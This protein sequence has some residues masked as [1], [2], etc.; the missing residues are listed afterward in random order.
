MHN[1][2]TPS[3]QQSGLKLNIDANLTGGVVYKL[4]IDFDAARSIV[5]KGNG[6]YLLK[7]VIRTYTEAVSGAISGNVSPAEALPYIMAITGTDTLGTY[8]TDSGTFKIN[9]V[10]AGTWSVKFDPKDPYADTTVN[11][12]DCLE[13]NSHRMDTVFFKQQ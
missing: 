7:P 5:V 13:W 12:V 3:A 10:P 2:E 1:L 9:G 6:D 8:A 11:D 4:W